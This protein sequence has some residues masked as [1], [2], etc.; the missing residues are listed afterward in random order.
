MNTKSYPKQK[1]ICSFLLG[2]RKYVLLNGVSPVF[3]PYS[4]TD[5]MP[6]TADQQKTRFG[7][8]GG[9]GREVFLSV[10]VVLVLFCV[11]LGFVNFDFCL[12]FS[13]CFGNR[14]RKNIKLG[15]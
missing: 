7:V 14:E 1:A 12:L 4:S 9:G 3:Q 2:K 5:T 15:G 10:V 13:F 6:R 11:L 8:C